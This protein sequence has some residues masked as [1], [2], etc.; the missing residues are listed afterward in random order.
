[1]TVELSC[2]LLARILSAQ[3][4]LGDET[5]GLYERSLAISIRNVGP[6][7]EYATFGNSN[8][9]EFHQKLARNQSTVAA[10]RMHLLLAKSHH[11]E[12]QRILSKIHGPTHPRT[13]NVSSR[14]TS[15]L[16]ALSQL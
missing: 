9:S 12:T 14:L 7:G 13:V 3:G 10:T 11:E 2:D 16:I 8:I 5:R 4:K 15:T 6:D 1:M